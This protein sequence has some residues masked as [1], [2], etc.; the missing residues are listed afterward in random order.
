MQRPDPIFERATDRIPRPSPLFRPE[1][2]ANQQ[3]KSYGEIILI[4]PLP[5]VLLA[6]LALAIVGIGAG[7][8]IFGRYTETARVY[9]TLLPS[10]H[11]TISPPRALQAELDLPR[12]LRPWVQPGGHLKLLCRTCPV[13]LL[14]QTGTVVGISDAPLDSPDS[15]PGTA[16][17]EHP[18][19]IMVSLPV[20]SAVTSGL[21]HSSQAETRVEVDLPLGRKPLI[22]WF[23][24]R[25]RN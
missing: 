4:R 5:L 1:A 24:E 19:R 8:L 12:R 11:D 2:L 9:G 6:F 18:Y 10:T 14:E 15:V 17:D 20:S 23:F 25:P 3:Q 22:N 13:A 21:S 7:C 16:T